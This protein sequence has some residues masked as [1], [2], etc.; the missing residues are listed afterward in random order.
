MFSLFRW[1]GP[2][3]KRAVAMVFL[4]AFEVRVQKLKGGPVVLR[5]VVSVD[6]GTLLYA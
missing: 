4:L 1:F 2:Q 6:K 3:I 5:P